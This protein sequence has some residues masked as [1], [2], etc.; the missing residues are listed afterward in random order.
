M[1]LTVFEEFSFV[2]TV[3]PLTRPV[4]GLL[5]SAKTAEETGREK[6]SDSEPSTHLLPGSFHTGRHAGIAGAV[7]TAGIEPGG[8][9][10]L[11]FRFLLI[12]SAGCF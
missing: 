10:C 8:N 2:Q 1:A 11:V 9:G 4:T 6:T 3:T 12:A 7:Q 5:V